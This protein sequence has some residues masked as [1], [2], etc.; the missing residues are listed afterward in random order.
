MKLITVEG[1]DC[2]WIETPGRGS[3]E[4]TVSSSAADEKLTSYERVSTFSER[5]IKAFDEFM[6]KTYASVGIQYLW[7]AITSPKKSISETKHKLEQR[8][9]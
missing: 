6:W 9:K 4:W 8:I 7:R 2:K 1:D 3:T 5:G